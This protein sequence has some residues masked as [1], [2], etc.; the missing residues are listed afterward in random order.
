[1]LAPLFAMPT[2]AKVHLDCIMR[3][4][5]VD[6]LTHEHACPT[7]FDVQIDLWVSDYPSQARHHWHMIEVLAQ[8]NSGD[9]G[10]RI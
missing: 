2:D 7:W 8:V 5:P 6:G 1:M 9:Q 3:G 4:R 10:L